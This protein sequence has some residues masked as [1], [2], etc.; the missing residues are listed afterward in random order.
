[1]EWAVKREKSFAMESQVRNNVNLFLKNKNNVELF[2]KNKNNVKLYLNITYNFFIK[3]IFSNNFERKSCK[4]FEDITHKG[5]V[6]V[7]IIT[8]YFCII[9]SNYLET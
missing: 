2:L 5:A 3:V 4:L 7:L 1:M 8:C 6:F 9:F